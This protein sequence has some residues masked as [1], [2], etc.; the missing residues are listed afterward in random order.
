MKPKKK[1]VL[2]TEKNKSTK[3]NNN[4]DEQLCNI[5]KTG[6]ANNHNPSNQ[7]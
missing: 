5:F 6:N 2:K 1:K 7:V 3:E 4:E